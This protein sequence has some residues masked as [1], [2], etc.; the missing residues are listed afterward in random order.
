MPTKPD[1]VFADNRLCRLLGIRFRAHIDVGEACA[2]IVSGLG[3]PGAIVP[4]AHA[5]GIK[6]SGPVLVDQ[7][8][9]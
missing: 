7:P 2:V 6:Q 9:Q 8:A 5:A 1:D 4:Q 3:D